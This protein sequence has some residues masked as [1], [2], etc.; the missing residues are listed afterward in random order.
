SSDP[1]AVAP[2][3]VPLG[4]KAGNAPNLSLRARHQP[5]DQAMAGEGANGVVDQNGIDIAGVDPRRERTEAGK[6]GPVPD[7][8]ARHDRAELRKA[9]A[10]RFAGWE[11]RLTC[12]Q[13]HVVVEG[14]RDKQF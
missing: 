7:I 5:L 11:V 13:H 4:W 3:G 9:T 1:A 14:A 8:A 12:H 10:K 6:L 2:D